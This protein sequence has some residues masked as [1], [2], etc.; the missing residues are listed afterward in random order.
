MQRRLPRRALGDIACRLRRR[1]FRRKPP[2]PPIVGAL[3][4]SP[5]MPPSFDFRGGAVSI[6][7]VYGFFSAI[8]KEPRVATPPLCAEPRFSLRVIS[9]DDIDCDYRAASRTCR[10][11]TF[12]LL[13]Y[14]ANSF[15]HSRVTLSLADASFHFTSLAQRLRDAM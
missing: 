3:F 9:I 15:A 7:Y 10:A 2:T 5:M 14:D 6:S 12:A 8:F 1:L 11:A 4:F 13:Q